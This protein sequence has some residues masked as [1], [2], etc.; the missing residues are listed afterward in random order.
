V[1]FVAQVRVSLEKFQK[2][3]LP[4]VCVFTGA[5]AREN[6]LM[7]AGSR[8]GAVAGGLPMTAQA[9]QDMR[10]LQRIT[11]GAFLVSVVA[12]SIGIAGRSAVWVGLGF[13]VLG[14]AIGLLVLTYRRSVRARVEG[15]HVLLAH[16][17]PQFASAISSPKKRCDNCS[18]AG[19][20]SVTEMEACEA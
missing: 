7:A 15:D 11:L 3:E 20:C 6:Y 9:V 19:S 10:K 4:N 2:G 8:D 5:I 14:S 13:A 18:G 16:V 12:T 17:H 1:G